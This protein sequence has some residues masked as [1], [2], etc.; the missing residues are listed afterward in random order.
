MT[1]LSRK[2]E[3]TAYLSD[4]VNF[5]LTTT[6][7]ISIADNLVDVF[8][9]LVDQATNF[10]VTDTGAFIY[11]SGNVYRV[12]NTV[13]ANRSVIQQVSSSRANAEIITLVK[14]TDYVV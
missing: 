1:V 7:S 10:L 2:L 14:D 4:P 3:V 6:E 12:S 11:T 8:D 9:L 13:S 5:T